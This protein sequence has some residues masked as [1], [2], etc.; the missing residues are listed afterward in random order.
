MSSAR[1]ERLPTS[2]STLSLSP[3]TPLPPYVELEVSPPEDEL[4]DARPRRPVFPVDPR[5]EQPTPS[6]LSRAAL[7]VFIAL[8]FWLAFTLRR[9][10]WIGGLA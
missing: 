10:A 7:L 4:E 6:P 1:Y 9:A 3:L 8:M 5:F 2:D